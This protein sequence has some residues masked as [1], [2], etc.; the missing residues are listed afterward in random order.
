MSRVARAPGPVLFSTVAGAFS[1]LSR[2]RGRRI[3]HPY[4]VGF[5]AK[6]HPRG[7]GA[8]GSRLFDGAEPVPA[9]VR[10][11]RSLGLPETLADPCGLSFRIPHA[12]GD[13]Q[14]QDFLLVTSARRP[15]ARHLLLPARGFSARTYSCLLPY[16]IG[17]RTMLV[18]AEPVDR[19]PGPGVA[20]LSERQRG[21][22]S[23]AITLATPTG[24]WREVAR[25]EL[26]AQMAADTVEALRF[27]PAH[28]G[29]G[30]E[31]V[32]WL[33]DIR[34]AAYRGS[35]EGRRR[36]GPVAGGFDPGRRDAPDFEEAI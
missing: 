2:L 14:H 7:D 1:G 18:G 19:P 32:G 10:L 25:L 29:G 6:L 11:S 8:T 31:P 15:G 28:A 22:L 27:N 30:I 13:D 21:E 34:P 20:E 24:G 3:F 26:G 5:E 23:F 17:K 4:G 12:Y 36:S 9:V 16:R 33:N 35:Q